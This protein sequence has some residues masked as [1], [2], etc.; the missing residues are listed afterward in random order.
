[1]WDDIMKTKYASDHDRCGIR[2]VAV[3]TNSEGSRTQFTSLAPRTRWAL[4]TRFAFAT[5]PVMHWPLGYV[6][7]AWANK[8]TME[9]TL[10]IRSCGVVFPQADREDLT[11]VDICIH[12]TT[13]LRRPDI[14][15]SDLALGNWRPVRRWG[16][17]DL[18]GTC[19]PSANA[20]DVLIVQATVFWISIVSTLPSPSS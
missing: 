16:R 15:P 1:M 18:G 3:H 2:V 12:G 10:V 17:T 7:A 4:I 8:E 6:F 13:I 9:V 11:C 20:D 5:G 14:F 19:I